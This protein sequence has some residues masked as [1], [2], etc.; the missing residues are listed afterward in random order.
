MQVPLGS[1]LVGYRV[2]LQGRDPPVTVATRGSRKP[3]N[4]PASPPLR[5]DRFTSAPRSVHF[6]A[7]IGSVRAEIGS[8]P[9]RDRFSPRGRALVRQ[10]AAQGPRSYP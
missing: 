2:N 5:R 9:R 6:R 3:R 7:E 4:G 8:L 1:G 10:V